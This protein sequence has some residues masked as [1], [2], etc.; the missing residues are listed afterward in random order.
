MMVTNL[1]SAIAQGYREFDFLRGDEDYKL[2][3]GAD[4][5]PSLQ[6]RIVPPHAI[7]RTRHR[8]WLTGEVYDP[9][10]TAKRAA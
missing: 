7:A 6:I 4:P 9:D 1:K 3:W 8:L 2:H 5:R 10:Y